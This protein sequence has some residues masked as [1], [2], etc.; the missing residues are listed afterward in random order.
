MKRQSYFTIIIS[1]K[2]KHIKTNFE[3]FFKLVYLHNAK[4]AN[5]RIQNS[6]HFLNYFR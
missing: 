1:I 2:K 4:L 5:M 3:D 6:L